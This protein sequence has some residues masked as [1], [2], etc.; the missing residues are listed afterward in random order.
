VDYQVANL[1]LDVTQPADDLRSFAALKGWSVSGPSNGELY[2][3]GLDAGLRWYLRTNPPS[4]GPTL[5]MVIEISTGLSFDIQPGPQ[6]RPGASDY[7]VEED[8]DGRRKLVDVRQL[9]EAA[10]NWIDNLEPRYL[11]ELAL[12][13]DEHIGVHPETVAITF[14]ANGLEHALDRAKTLRAFA[15][16]LPRRKGHTLPK[17]LRPL[18]STIRSWAI[19]DDAKREA[20]LSAASKPQLEILVSA[21][22]EHLDLVNA[23]IDQRPDTSLS[24]RLM[25]FCQ[26]AQEAELL[27]RTRID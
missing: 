3:R 25:A 22:R 5:T 11:S 15:G 1:F 26:A 17:E 24:A 21:W 7:R 2:C 8:S 16:L 4:L 23:T 13:K 27:L 12:E 10:Q 6:V 9:S 19:S 20:R 14:R 18:T